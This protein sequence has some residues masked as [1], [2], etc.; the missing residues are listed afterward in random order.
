MRLVALLAFVF[1][2]FLISCSSNTT[3][4]ELGDKLYLK[5]KTRDGKALDK[6]GLH[7]YYNVPYSHNNSNG[8]KSHFDISDAVSSNNLSQNYPNPFDSLSHIPLRLNRSSR[9]SLSIL[10]KYDSTKVIKTLF[11]DSLY[12]DTTAHDSIIVGQYTYSWDGT[13]EAGEY[14]TNN[15]YD[16]QLIVNGSIEKKSLSLNRSNPESIKSLDC[17]PLSTSDRNG[18]IEVEYNTFPI[19]YVIIFDDVNGVALGSFHLPSEI[20]LVL[21]KDGYRP[22]TQ[23]VMIIEDE[24]LEI[25]IEMERE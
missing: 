16:Y 1:V 19:N 5:V 9:V 8:R 12:V 23:D 10:N 2:C 25:T 7:F 17:L 18:I 15:V 21:I 24:P 13:N 11:D 22:A 4:E 6:V 3:P 20:T 14:V